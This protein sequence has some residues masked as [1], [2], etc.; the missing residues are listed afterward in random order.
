MPATAT[1]SSPAYPSPLPDAGIAATEWALGVMHG[2]QHEAAWITPVVN[3]RNPSEWTGGRYAALAGKL[4]D[5]AGHYVSIGVIKEG[6]TRSDDNVEAVAVLVFDDVGDPIQTDVKMDSAWLYMRLEPTFIVETSLGNYQWSYVFDT[7]VGPDDY[8]ILIEGLKLVPEAAG[9]IKDGTSLSRYVRLPSGKNPKAEKGGFKT[10]LV[11][12]S[13]KKYSLEEISAAFGLQ[14]KTT[15]AAGA[16]KAKS[17]PIPEALAL[18]EAE[19]L[20]LLDEI[21]PLIRNNG[22]GREDWI[23]IVYGFFN[24]S[25]RNDDV[26]DIVERFTAKREDGPVNSVDDFEHVWKTKDDATKAGL[27]TLIRWLEKQ[28]TPAADKMVDRIRQVQAK[29]KFTAEAVDN[30]GDNSPG[31]G[32]AAVAKDRWQQLREATRA[33]PS[34][35]RVAGAGGDGNVARLKQGIAVFGK[36]AK[37][38]PAHERLFIT[39]RLARGVVSVLNGVPGQGKTAIAVAYMNAIACE[40]PAL[41][42]LSEIR[43]AGACVYMAADGEKADEIKRR[44]EAFR[45]RHGL[46]SSDYKHNI[47]VFDEPG[48]FLEMIDGVWVPTSW[49]ISTARGLAELREKNGLAVI[50]VDTLSG[51]AGGGKLSDDTDMQA[52]MAVARILAAGLNCAVDL[53]NHLTKGGAKADPESMDAG[54]GARALTAVPKFVTNVIAE[55]GDMIRLHGAKGTYRDGPVGMEVMRWGEEMVPVEVWEEG[56]QTGVSTSAIGVLV[57]ENP[58]VLAQNRENAAVQAIADAIQKD[59]MT[60]IRSKIG[61]GGR[62]AKDHAVVIVRGAVAGLSAQAADDLIG[63]LI[64]QGKLVSIHRYDEER[65]RTIDE[66]TLPRLDEAN[67]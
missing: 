56:V 36:D 33:W 64:E 4:V 62:P 24:A 3:I 17:A 9:G 39:N 41:V 13:G 25:G 22:I 27:T 42:G 67:I 37:A 21:E 34:R 11:A 15:G 23:G 6:S 5:H 63:T 57:P 19:A 51:M 58:L 14:H 35:D 7:P 20:A 52:V 31:P 8:R 60:V 1:T 55:A 38:G 26:E 47:Y 54:G 32:A 16:G 28:A 49:I 12:G 61:K 53:I 2:P 10:R 66:V 44:D 30:S 65:K 18:P 29:T 43:R 40:K 46:T 48:A 50:T 59:G 45:Q